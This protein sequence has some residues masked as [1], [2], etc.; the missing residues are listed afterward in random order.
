MQDKM[1]KIISLSKRRG[2]IFPSSEIYGGFGSVYDFGPLGAL[3]KLNLKN[4][5]MKNMREFSGNVVLLDSGI[6]MTPKV[7]EASGHLSAGFADELAECT[8]CKKRFK[9]GDTDGKHCPECKKELL[10]PRKFNL[11]M[12]TFIG[13]AEDTASVAYLRAET[14]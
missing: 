11:M 9:Q 10:P 12:R 14:C 3:L 4:E 5:W 1:Q 7:W 6:L 13:P 8:G 2:F